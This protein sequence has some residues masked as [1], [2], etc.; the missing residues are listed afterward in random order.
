MR[1]TIPQ[2]LL[3]MILTLNACSP[4]ANAAPATL[5]TTEKTQI[6]SAVL[7]TESDQSATWKQYTNNTFGFGFQ[8]PSNWFGPSEYIS[9]G[10]LRVEVGSDKVYP[11]GEP[12]E[13]PSVVKNSYNVVIQYTKNDQNT[14]WNDNYQLLQNLKDG[15]SQSGTRSQIIRVRQLEIGRFKGFEY[16]STLSETAQTDHVYAREV[17]LVD[18]Q[19]NDLLTIMGQ[20]NNVEVSDGTN[21]REIYQ[22]IDEANQILFD[23]IVESITL[24]N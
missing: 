18:E 12:P 24:S 17:I 2:F 23:K 1:K 15:E 8:Y 10:T 4:L 16:I 21:W 14:Y 9:G 22:T 6:P 7:A 3:M 11:Y 19:T 5:P 20:P 13:Q